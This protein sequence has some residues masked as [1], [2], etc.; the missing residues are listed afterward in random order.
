[1]TSTC[2]PI[3]DHTSLPNVERIHPH[4]DNSPHPTTEITPKE[5]TLKDMM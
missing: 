4:T 5:P 1:M 2:R 3:H